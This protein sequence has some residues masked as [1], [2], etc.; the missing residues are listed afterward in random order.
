MI[1]LD[2]YGYGIDDIPPEPDG[3]KP[4]IV[5]SSD[6]PSIR[7]WFVVDR[8]L[9]GRFPIEFVDEISRLPLP[10]RYD[11]V[12]DGPMPMSGQNFDNDPAATSHGI[13]VFAFDI[14][15]CLRLFE[16]PSGIPWCD[17]IASNRS[18]H[19]QLVFSLG[20][21]KLLN[22]TRAIGQYPILASF[23]ELA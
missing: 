21:G 22:P 19:H 13:A 3:Y 6:L 4:E 1:D 9:S 7:S 14:R 16:R 5:I 10:V 23:D 15:H 20:E 12:M 8:P 18:P 2:R 11:Q 17:Q